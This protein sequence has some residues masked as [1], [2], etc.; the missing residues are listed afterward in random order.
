MRKILLLLILAAVVLGCAGEKVEKRKENVTIYYFYSPTCPNCQAV[1]PYI[2]YLM[3]STDVNFVLC[4]VKEFDNC[5]N[6][7]IELAKAIYSKQGFFGVPTAVVK[8][9]GNYTVFIGKYD[10]LKLSEFLEKLGYSVP[11]IEISDKKIDAAKCVECHERR[12]IPPPREM[13]CSYCCHLS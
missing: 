3:N 12:G 4:N 2:D 11:K 7:S 6:E 8:Y 9:R 10:V 13:N 1:E 5:T